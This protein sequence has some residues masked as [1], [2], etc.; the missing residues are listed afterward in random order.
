MDH[1]GDAK[2]VPRHQ[3]RAVEVG[4]V[5]VGVAVDGGVERP[6]DDAQRGVEA[7]RQ[8]VADWAVEVVAEEEVVAVDGVFEYDGEAD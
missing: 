8:A 4:F 5:G 2:L 7:R 6:F 1:I 3:A